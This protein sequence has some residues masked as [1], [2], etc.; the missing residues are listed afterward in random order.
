MAKK[1]ERAKRSDGLLQK[2]FRINGKFYLVY[3]HSEAEL[4]EAEKA[5]RDAIEKGLE[6]R[7]NPTLADYYNRWSEARRGCVK[8]TTLRS[9][10]KIYGVVAKIYIQSASRTLGELKVKEI[11]IDDLRT[12]Q[13]ELLKSRSTRTVNDYMAFINHLMR[14]ALKERIIDYNPCV[15]LNTLKRTEEQARDTNHRALTVEETKAFFGCDRCKESSY[16]NVYRLAINTGMR[17]GEIGALKYTDIRHDEIHIERTITRAEGGN[18]IIGEDA[19]TK[20]GRRI[21]PM[22]EAIKAI[23]KAQKELNEMIYGECIPLDDC[24]FKSPNGGLLSVT[25]LDRD[26]KRICT[27]ANIEPFSM[28]AF[29][30]TFATR[31][32]E[33]EMNPKTLQEILGHSNFNIT[34]SLYG[35]CLTDTKKQAMDKV[36]IAI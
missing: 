6:R 10:D 29:R 4:F 12:V 16:Y 14:D 19:K 36:I 22:N 17:A 18:Y 2:G 20:A 1:I 15:L 31:A 9:Q 24:L 21:I 33:N 11:T 30:A 34:M 13:A 35:H 32:I 7:Y 5:K 23:V 25:Q 28:H 3:G 8:E 27:A 26:I